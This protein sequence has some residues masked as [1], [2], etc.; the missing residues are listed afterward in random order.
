MAFEE[1]GDRI[2]A[3][4]QRLY[5]N[6]AQLGGKIGLPPS[7]LSRLEKG[8]I[9]PPIRVIKA[10]AEHL[11]V[12]IRY[13]QEVQPL[14]FMVASLS[15]ASYINSRYIRD[16]AKE[17]YG[18]Q[19]GLTEVLQTP[20]DSPH[21]LVTTWHVDPEMM[22]RLVDRM[23]IFRGFDR[24]STFFTL[25]QPVVTGEGELSVD[26]IIDVDVNDNPFY[27][28]ARIEEVMTSEG[29]T[30][31]AHAVTGGDDV[32][33]QTSVEGWEQLEAK[34]QGFGSVR[35]VWNLQRLPID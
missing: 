22:E 9:K 15:H 32:F 28:L 5:L 14:V 17:V 26:R 35:E 6:Q 11:G 33:I 10:A 21:H 7:V 13:L 4:R 20:E 2:R 12:S 24:V 25:G 19:P 29:I 31:S 23:R 16:L 3:E 27:G 8:L 30:A 18:R 34:L 1:V